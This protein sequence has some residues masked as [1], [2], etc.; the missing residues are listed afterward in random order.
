MHPIGE[1][2]GFDGPVGLNALPDKALPTMK[3]GSEQIARD[4]WKSNALWI[5][6]PKTTRNAVRVKGERTDRRRPAGPA[7][8]MWISGSAA[9][10]NPVILKVR[11]P[12]RCR[13]E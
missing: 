7:G 5:S 1:H 9:T 10:R 12:A 3:E 13:C 2:S 4:V 6:T 8:D 11:V